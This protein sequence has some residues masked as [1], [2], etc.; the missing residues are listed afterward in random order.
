MKGIDRALE[1]PGWMSARE[2]RWLAA[3][4]AEH[5]NILEIGAWRGR[6]TR[7]LA[8]NTEGRVTVVDDWSGAGWDY[9]EDMGNVC[10]RF[11]LNLADYLSTGKVRV[12]KHSSAQAYEELWGELFDLTFVDGD[13]RYEAVKRDLELWAPLTRGILCGHDFGT[14]GG[15]AHAVTEQF[16]DVMRVEG[17]SIWWVHV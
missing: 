4:A 2:L 15:V 3:R 13:H 5:R 16:P 10:L 12:L 9:D 11:T 1:I 8:D 14:M 17:T 7:A 6:S